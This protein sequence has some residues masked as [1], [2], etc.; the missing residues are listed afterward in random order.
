M[1]LLVVNYEYPPLGSG[2]G[3]QSKHIARELAR[4]C[5][6]VYL[7][8]TGFGEYGIRAEDGVTVH[9]LKTSRARTHICTNGEMLSFVVAA[10]RALPEILSRNK[11]D[12]MLVFFGVPTGLVTFHPAARNIPCVI[13]VCGSDVPWHNPDRFRFLYYFFTPVIK[14]LW[15]RAKKVVCNS[16]GLS[17]EVR[18]IMPSITPAVIPNGIDTELFRP[19]GSRLIEGRLRLLYTGRLIPLKRIDLIIRALPELKRLSGL[20]VS[21]E[22]AGEGPQERELKALS[23]ELGIGDSVH[24]AGGVPH[25]GIA[26]YYRAAH[27][28]VQMSCTEGMSNSL[29]EAVSCGLPVVTSAFNGTD[30]LV[31]GNGTVLKNPEPCAIAAAI[32][33]YAGDRELYRK[34]CAASREL[35]AQFSW[36]AAARGYLRELGG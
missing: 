17:G 13:S 31:K 5:S 1:R 15:K 6:A 24:F 36:A 28:Y 23:R 10:W 25:A 22:I 30:A 9:R 12:A 21:L 20:E 29:L 35:S 34:H 33:V 7:L 19:P 27:V 14:L 4:N 11:F 32:A 16:D 3:T 18:A 2:G 8:T 26:D